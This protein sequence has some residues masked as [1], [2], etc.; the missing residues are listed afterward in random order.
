MKI[1]IICTGNTC[2]SQMAEGFLRSMDKD[3]EVYSA[4]TNAETLV[5]PY[6][7]KVMAEKGIDISKQVPKS[8]S[9][10]LKDAFDYVMTVCDDAKESCPFFSGKVKHRLHIGLEDPARATGSDEEKL[11]VYRKVRDEIEKEFRDFYKQL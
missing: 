7:V 6:A 3:L 2:R 10:F 9:L 1:L 5:N 8:V 4:G 11:K